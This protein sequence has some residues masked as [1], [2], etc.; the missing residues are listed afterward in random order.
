MNIRPIKT[1]ADHKEA[2]R[3]IEA[4]WDADPGT[5]ESQELDVLATLIAAYEEVH[6]P[7]PAPHPIDAINFRMEQLGLKDTDLKPYIGAR[8]KVSE[9]MNLRRPLSLPMIRKL[10]DG[11]QISGQTLIREYTL[12]I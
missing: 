10:S 1:K 9:V 3:R 12:S 2:L 8:S 7:I 6:Y 4:L 5:P 11:L